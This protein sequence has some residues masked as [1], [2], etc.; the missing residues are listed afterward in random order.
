MLKV[1]QF[2]EQVAPY[3]ISL[4]RHFRMHPETGRKEFQTQERIMAELTKMGLK[5]QKIN[6]TGVLAEIK[7][8]KPGKTAAL[9]ADIDALPVNDEIEQ[10]YKS[11]V[12]GV[13][14]A[15]GH[16]A[17][18]ALALGVAKLFT[19]AQNEL[20]G[21]VRFLF[22]PSEELLPDGGALGMIAAGALDGVDAII[23]AHVWQ[24]IEVGK[25][26][27]AH[28]KLMAAPDEFAITIKGRGGH[29]SMPQ[30][31][32][33]PIVVGAQIILLL[34]AITAS[35]IDPRESAVLTVG[36][37]KAGEVFNIIPDT[38]VIKGTVR[39]FAEDVR[40]K[41]HQQ[42]DQ[43]CRGC[44][45]TMGADYELKT[46]LGFPPVINDPAISRLLA[47]ASQEIL[48]ADSVEEIQP[49]LVAEDFSYYLEK[50]PGA[51][52]FLGAGNKQEGIVFPHHHPKFDIDEGCLQNGIGVM[53]AAILKILEGGEK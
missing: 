23:G 17:H 21:K 24:P 45:Q 16:D 50:V 2:A 19:L 42:I 4:R 5:P 8:A 48:G 7:G 52:F 27:I 26:G 10:P 9:R 46:T 25:I 28:G 11:T 32:I 15:C 47:A 13:S 41:I 3:A 20:C 37:F 39:S 14:H 51:Y 1:I 29:G 38:A 36:M 49:T 12:A 34:R 30:Q 22:Q 6:G 35:A 40:T 33:D 43:I 31:T 53:A 44:C 18:I